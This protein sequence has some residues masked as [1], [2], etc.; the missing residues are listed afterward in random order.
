MLEPQLQEILS[1]AD[2]LSTWRKKSWDK[3]RDL[4]SLELKQDAFRYVPIQ[5][6]SIPKASSKDLSGFQSLSQRPYRIIFIDGFFSS[7]HSLLPD[8]VICSPLDEAMSSYG[9]FLQTRFTK[10]LNEETDPFAALNGA[11]QGQGAFV[12]IPPKKQFAHPIFIEHFFTNSDMAT[13][14]L[15]LYVGK[16]SNVEIFQ[17]WHR[18]EASFVNAYVDIALDEAATLK[19]KTVE[20][21][22]EKSHLFQS[23]RVSSKKMSQFTFRLYSEGAAISRHSLRVQLLEEGSEALLQGIA[24]LEKSLQHHIHATVEHCAEHTK[25]RQ[26]FKTLLRD[27]SCSSFE[28]KI[29]VHPEAQKTESYQ[30]NNVLLLSDTAQSFAKP[31]LEV[32]ADDVKASHGATVS[33]LD[34][35]SLF[36]LRSRGLSQAD[37]QL[38]LVESF[39]KELK[40]CLP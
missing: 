29:Y 26:H 3:F 36:Y 20:K 25:S 4:G 9:V 5:N 35:E 1:V 28:G 27:T 11:F 6:L 34:A 30:L 19:C 31:N 10:G 16:Q 7:E 18:K 32:L 17:E 23:W 38:L 40:E 14:R 2:S 13:P 21:A 37:A 24:T 22:S 39:V 15:I 12:Y 33:Q 8:D